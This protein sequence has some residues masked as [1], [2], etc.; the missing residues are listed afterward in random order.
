MSSAQLRD[1]HVDVVIESIKKMD[2]F[3]DITPEERHVLD[4]IHGV[5]DF[6]EESDE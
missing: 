4:V 3:Y 5:A 2:S 6:A 1:R